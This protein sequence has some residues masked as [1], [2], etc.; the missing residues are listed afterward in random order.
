MIKLNLHTLYGKQ[1]TETPKTSMQLWTYGI[2]RKFSYK[3]NKSRD[4]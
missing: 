3:D 4:L 2:L 1:S